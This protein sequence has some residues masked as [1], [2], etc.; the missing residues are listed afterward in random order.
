[1]KGQDKSMLRRARRLFVVLFLSISVA[2]LGQELDKGPY[3]QNLTSDGVT[4]CWVTRS[5]GD[6]GSEYVYHQ[7]RISGLKPSTEYA[8]AAGDNGEIKGTFRTAPAGAEP[9]TF[10]ALGDTR[11][12]PVAHQSVVN[13][14]M[15]VNPRF[16]V[17]TGDLVGSGDN[18]DSWHEFFKVTGELM[19]RVP[20]WPVLGNHESNSVNYYNYFAL[21]G[22]E[23]YYSFD[24]GTTHFVML[25]SDDLTMPKQDG[26]QT[27]ED[28]AA[29][30]REARK[31]YWQK[32]IQWLETDLEAHKDADFIFV[33]FHHP[34]YS[35][36]SS[37]GRR[38]E[39]KNTR[40]RFEVLLKQ[41]KVS[42]VLNGHDHFY[43]RNVVDGMYCIV[44]GG[45]GAPLYSFG[46]PLPTSAKRDNVYHFVRID[47]NG[48]T[49]AGTVLAPDDEVIDTFQ[50]RS[51]H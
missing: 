43:E 48:S 42:A 20:Y 41:Y 21:P 37:S 30:Y 50:I 38:M 23:R 12:N 24:Y 1:M 25:D 16:V 8:Y 40:E 45:G 34:L 6:Q 11:T 7:A 4:V 47:I 36:T 18:R 35:S 32:Q 5:S 22:N 26:D 49:A 17:N 28:T 3:L 33:A 14:V 19:K 9:F 31:N 46:E 44:T 51:R 13:A 2:A 27:W 15:V 29:L 10:I 39:Q